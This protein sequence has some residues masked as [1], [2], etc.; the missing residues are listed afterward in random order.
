MVIGGWD[1]CRNGIYMGYR[2]I[3][4]LSITAGMSLLASKKLIAK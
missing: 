4:V 1:I 2:Q 3:K